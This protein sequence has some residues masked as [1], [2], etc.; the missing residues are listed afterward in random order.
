MSLLDRIDALPAEMIH[1]IFKHYWDLSSEVTMY[2]LDMMPR[3]TF[4]VSYNRE[5]LD[6]GRRADPASPYNKRIALN[7]KRTRQ[8]T[9]THPMLSRMVVSFASIDQIIAFERNPS[10][11]KQFS[12]SALTYTLLLPNHPNI[13]MHSL[14][15]LLKRNPARESD[16]IAALSRA[17]DTT[18]IDFATKQPSRLPVP[19]RLNEQSLHFETATDLNNFLY[20]DMSRVLQME[21]FSFGCTPSDQCALEV[22]KFLFWSMQTHESGICGAKEVYLIAHTKQYSTGVTDVDSQTGPLLGVVIRLTEHPL[23]NPHPLLVSRYPVRRALFALEELSLDASEAMSNQDMVDLGQVQGLR[24]KVHWPPKYISY[25]AQDQKRL[26]SY[27]NKLTMIAG[28]RL[29]WEYTGSSRM[30]AQ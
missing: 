29:I 26:K 17:L 14:L 19:N 12:M 28:T 20:A 9:R 8:N 2:Q 27:L 22:L 30:A 23:N 13:R 6:L 7:P 24:P 11:V 3:D 15:A 18:S 5:S 25:N 10:P 1:N 16:D 21:S 4:S